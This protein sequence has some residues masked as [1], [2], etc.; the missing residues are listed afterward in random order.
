MRSATWL[1]A[2][3]LLATG[4]TD[5]TDVSEDQFQAAAAW[6]RKVAGD[7]SRWQPGGLTKGIARTEG[8]TF[9]TL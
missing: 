5:W 2:L 1:W 8:W 9:G 7:P 4:V 3:A 6:L